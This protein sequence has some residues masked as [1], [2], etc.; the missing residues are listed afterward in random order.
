MS[1]AGSQTSQVFDLIFG[2]LELHGFHTNEAQASICSVTPTT[3][4]NW[5]TGKVKALNSGKLEEVI[6]RIYFLSK[7]RGV[8][9]VGEPSLCPIVIEEGAGPEDLER[10]LRE[11]WDSVY[12]GHKFLYYHPAGAMAWTQLLATGYGNTL[13]SKGFVSALTA[14]LGGSSRTSA[15]KL[16]AALRW[17]EGKSCGVD[18]IS[19][20]PGDGAK[21]A[22][23]IKLLID[24]S[25]PNHRLIDWLT[26][27]P[28]D[29]SI[30]LLRLASEKARNLIR[31]KVESERWP[32]FLVR[33]SCSDFEDGNIGFAGHL[34][35]ADDDRRLVLF[36]GGTFGNLKS[37]TVF[38]ERTLSRVLRP[39]DLLWLEVGVRQTR[40]E[41]D[42]LYAL[43]KGGLGDTQETVRR[44]LVEGPHRRFR[45]SVGS[46]LESNMRIIPRDGGVTCEVPRSHNFVHDVDI[47][48][49]G[50]RCSVLYSRRYDVAALQQWLLG[51]GYETLFEHAVK[52]SLDRDRTAHLLLRRARA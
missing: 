35:E 3:I 41:D 19:L 24:H 44:A 18:L 32:H 30:P 5:K 20:G 29:V 1:A 22:H 28:V 11:K 31:D 46:L 34:S 6:A 25:G 9:L 47:N 21:E 49:S 51:F 27:T 13:L 48:A 26:Y 50:Q 17:T 37:E 8:D 43:A 16:G 23:A 10:E 38:V 45:A 52:D 39:G 4:H 40:I 12:L 2:L 14:A 7:R 36:L 42:A 15:P 33:P